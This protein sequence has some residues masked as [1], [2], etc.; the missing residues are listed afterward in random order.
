MDDIVAAVADPELVRF[1]R[2]PCP[3]ST[4]LGHEFVDACTTVPG[5]ATTTFA[6]AVPDDGRPHGRLV[7]VVG[8][9]VDKRDGNAELGYWTAPAARGRGLTTAG[10][11]AVCA[12]GFSRLDLARIHLMASVDNVVSNRIA[13]RIGCTRTGV[14]R[15]A[16]L[17]RDAS[18]APVGR[19]DAATWDLL[20]GEVARPARP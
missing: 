9:D 13:E 19:S 10:A 18:G 17:L 7:G 15:A 11:R 8:L 20:P 4:A 1:T 3:Y 12:H 5:S 16:T 6:L 2:V 14:V